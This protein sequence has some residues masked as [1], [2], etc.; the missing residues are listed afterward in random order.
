MVHGHTRDKRVKI[1]QEMSR[2]S[3]APHNLRSID[4]SDLMFM[5]LFLMEEK[6]P[7][8]RVFVKKSA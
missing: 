4:Q 2:I 3:A 7:G 6:E 8:L 1:I 5:I